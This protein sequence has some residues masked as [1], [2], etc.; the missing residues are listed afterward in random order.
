M[1]LLFLPVE[2]LNFES[3][4]NILPSFV[5]YYHWKALLT[6]DKHLNTFWVAN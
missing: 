2:K 1:I 5:F 3:G 4:I 6:N